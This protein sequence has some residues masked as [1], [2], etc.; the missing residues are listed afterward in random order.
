[1]SA[2]SLQTVARAADRRR[3]AAHAYRAAI[4]AARADGVPVTAIADAAGITRNNVYR[5]LRRATHT[6]ADEI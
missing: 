4:V 1:M 5:L 6:T 2:R 3:E